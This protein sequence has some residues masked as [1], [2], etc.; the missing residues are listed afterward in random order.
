MTLA[1]ESEEIH[2][3]KEK[4]SEIKYSKAPY[5]HKRFKRIDH[6]EVYH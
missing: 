2:H 1:D 5:D 3:W 6:E 4:Q